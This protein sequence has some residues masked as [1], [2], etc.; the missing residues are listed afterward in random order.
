M[1]EILLYSSLQIDNGLCRLVQRRGSISIRPWDSLPFKGALVVII[2]VQSAVQSLAVKGRVVVVVVRVLA[3]KNNRLLSNII[4]RGPCS[5][6]GGT[7]A[8]RLESLNVME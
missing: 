3:E 7:T 5:C 2:L 1:M 4:L 6:L 8:E